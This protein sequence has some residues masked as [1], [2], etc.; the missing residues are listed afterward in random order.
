MPD[1]IYRANIDH[2]L[3]LLDDSNVATERHA[4]VVKLLIEEEDKLGYYQ[5]QLE[6][7]ES[8]AAN[9]RDRLNRQRQKLDA[10][11]QF[12]PH[13]AVAERLLANFEATQK[14]LDDFCH[15][16]RTKAMISRL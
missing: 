15:R 11:D 4:M 2:Y 13:R 14:L 5:E 6:F 7:A 1:F 8:R 3:E 12:A 16:L 10:I 9:G